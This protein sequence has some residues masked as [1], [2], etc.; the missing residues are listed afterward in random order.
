MTIE[1]NQYKSKIVKLLIS[2]LILLGILTYIFIS[3]MFRSSITSAEF[4]NILSDDFEF[5][6]KT[7]DLPEETIDNMTYANNGT[8]TIRY[9]DYVS[10]DLST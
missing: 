5:T 4:K 3:F 6:D 7:D 2:S 8:F 9:F 10:T 1:E